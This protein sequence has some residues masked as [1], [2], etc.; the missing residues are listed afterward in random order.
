MENV[1]RERGKMKIQIS[2]P[3]CFDE[4]R[5]KDKGKKVPYVPTYPYWEYPI[6][7]LDSW[8]NYYEFVCEK[9]HTN[10]F[11]LQIEL[12]E[13]LFQQATYCINDGYYREAIGT[14]N[15]AV[16]R[17]MEF[18][19]EMLFTMDNPNGVDFSDFW[20]L[21]KH[22]SERQIGAF[23]LLWSKHFK[24]KPLILENQQ[25]IKD[26]RKSKN[27]KELRNEVIH[28]GHIAS[29]EEAT[30]FGKITFD[31]LK[32]HKQIIFKAIEDE[33]FLPGI[34]Y[35]RIVHA[36]P[37][38][39]EALKELEERHNNGEDVTGISSVFVPSFLSREDLTS[40]EDCLNDKNI[41]NIGL[42]K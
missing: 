5:E 36:S 11:F 1:L 28:Q 23:Y 34:R 35:I 16:E 2:C 38:V 27:Y 13:M 39:K 29:K 41:H 20:K 17:F 9:G 19:I 31:Y 30:A 33:G 40:F 26:G 10:R 37:R 7:E 8:D 25:V 32:E 22:Q 4:G 18:S 6:I 42:L 12:F 21:I 14:F 3:K 15:T 24:R